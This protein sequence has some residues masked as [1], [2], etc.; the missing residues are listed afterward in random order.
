MIWLSTAV[1]SAATQA[2]PLVGLSLPDGALDCPFPMLGGA[3][4][5]GA[6]VAVTLIFLPHACAA[7]E[8]RKC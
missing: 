8:S 2:A 4:V 5:D 3:M 1:T 6:G 7:A